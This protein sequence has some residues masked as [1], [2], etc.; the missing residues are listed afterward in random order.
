V[1]HAAE[2]IQMTGINASTAAAEPTIFSMMTSL[3]LL[4]SR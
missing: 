4:F 1:A 3:E 2:E